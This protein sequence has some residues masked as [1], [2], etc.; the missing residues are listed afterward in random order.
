MVKELLFSRI[1]DSKKFGARL[2]NSLLENLFINEFVTFYMEQ[3]I[4]GDELI[5]IKVEG[6]KIKFQC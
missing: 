5:S 2:V 6:D 1:G 4:T 3:G